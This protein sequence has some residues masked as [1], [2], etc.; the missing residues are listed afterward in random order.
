M[1]SGKSTN[2]CSLGSMQL[3][4]VV[5]YS[6]VYNKL[7]CLF[8]ITK[9]TLNLQKKIVVNKLLIICQDPRLYTKRRHWWSL[10]WSRAHGALER[11]CWCTAFA[12]KLGRT[13][14]IWPLPT[15]RAST[16]ERL[17]YR[18]CYTWFLRYIWLSDHC[19]TPSDNFTPNV[20]FSMLNDVHQ[21][22]SRGNPVLR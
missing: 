8:H 14:L 16:Q 22:T 1:I 15:L 9:D 2:A 13:C 5:L 12:R 17:G 19:Y 20:P 6:Q 4:L 18:W 3:G 21:W 11:K 10:F 7:L